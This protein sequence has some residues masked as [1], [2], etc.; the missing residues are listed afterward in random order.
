MGHQASP[1]LP[2]D[3]TLIPEPEFPETGAGTHAP[4]GPSFW[5]PA[6]TRHPGCVWNEQTPEGN[7]EGR[8]EALGLRLRAD[9]S[10]HVFSSHVP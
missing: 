10:S 3:T 7:K 4:G 6:L 1:R 9:A 2:R 5:C 8:L